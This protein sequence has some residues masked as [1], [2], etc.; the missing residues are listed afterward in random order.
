MGVYGAQSI[1]QILGSG[2]A[3]TVTP[4]AAAG[5]GATTTIIGNNITGTVSITTGSGL[6]AST[7]NPLFTI[8][9]A[10]GVT[11]PNQCQLF[12]TPTNVSAAGMLT[13]AYTSGTKNSATVTIGGITLGSS[14]T[15]SFTYLITG[16]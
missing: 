15:Y 6:G 16:G 7:T 14:T 2:G 13:N 10:D 3:P 1:S 8:T 12:I 9:L 5:F 4:G 11:Y